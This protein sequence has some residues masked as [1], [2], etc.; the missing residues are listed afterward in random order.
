MG[1]LQG[2]HGVTVTRDWTVPR[3]PADIVSA[4]GLAIGQRYA[5]EVFSRDVVVHLR[6]GSTVPAVTDP[7]HILIRG[8]AQAF[9]PEA[10]EGIYLWQ[11]A[12]DRP[13]VIVVTETD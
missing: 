2:P 5:L 6:E 11:V 8:N 3:A 4:L 9:K 10:G 7:A 13:A 1:A 12:G